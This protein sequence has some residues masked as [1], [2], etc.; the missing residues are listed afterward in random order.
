[1]VHNIALDE[2]Y[3]LYC[4]KSAPSLGDTFQ[5]KT[6]IQVPVKSFAAID[7]RALG[8]LDVSDMTIK[9]KFFF[10][11]VLLTCVIIL[12]LLGQSDN[13][14]YVGNTTNVTSPCSTKTPTYFNVSDPNLNR[15][16]YDL[17]IYPNSASNDPKG[18][19]F[20][21][22]YSTSPLDVSW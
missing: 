19:G 13:V 2:Y 9:K 5:S 18:V 1:M 17:A 14:V 4:T 7:T 20:G 3:V 12:Q 11:L 21:L 8:Y 16:S 10:V 15:A 22:D 6:F